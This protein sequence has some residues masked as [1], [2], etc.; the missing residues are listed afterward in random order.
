MFAKANR[1]MI[2]ALMLLGLMLQ[3]CETSPPES[4]LD[5]AKVKA[6]Q[7]VEPTDEMRTNH[8]D[9][10]KH[11]QDATVYG[12]ERDTK[13]AFIT[14]INCHVPAE[15]AGKP[16]NYL[17]DDGDLNEEHF[18]ATC[19]KYSAVKIDC[20]ECHSDNPEGSMPKDA[21]HGRA[22]EGDK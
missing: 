20:F 19:H 17:T 14:C 6:E 3:G 1:L 7:C 12:G 11:Q 16:V 15:T 9:F 13:H 5:T 21:T 8:M 4:R 2:A 10:I 18:C 22:K